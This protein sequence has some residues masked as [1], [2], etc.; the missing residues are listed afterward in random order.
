MIEFYHWYAFVQEAH[1]IHFDF[2]FSWTHRLLPIFSNG[3]VWDDLTLNVSNVSMHRC[4]LP[5]LF[6]SNPVN[7]YLFYRPIQAMYFACIYPVFGEQALYYHLLQLLLHITVAY[8]LFILYCRFF[9][10]T[11]SLFLA[12]LFLLHP[13]NV[14]SVAW[15]SASANPMYLLFGISA[16]L[17]VTKGNLTLRK[18][19]IITPLLLLCTLTKDIGISFMVLTIGYMYIFRLRGL[20]PLILSGISISIIYM[21]MRMFLG[22]TTGFIASNLP[23]AEL[24]FPVRLL[25][26]PAIFIFYV[27]TFFYPQHLIIMQD[28]VV[29]NLTL[30]NFVI[31]LLFGVIFFA[32][33]FLSLRLLYKNENTII[34][35]KTHYGKKIIRANYNGLQ[36][37]SMR[38]R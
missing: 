16:L 33:L 3:F 13:I 27:T 29:R 23:I 28:W 34:A 19:A 20:K 2:A 38:W 30:Q 37:H 22:K 5:F 9:R 35:S 18:I 1:R 31:P 14:E 24:P 25:N 7:I 32:L 21:L 11:L 10:S 15:I 17:L 8:L 26:I 36:C 6:G 12:L 4:S